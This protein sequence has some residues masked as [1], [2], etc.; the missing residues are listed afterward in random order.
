MKKN[1]RRIPACMLSAAMI[2]SLF[3]AYPTVDAQAE[4][5]LNNTY[6]YGFDDSDSLPSEFTTL[7][8]SVSSVANGI[9]TVT[10]STVNPR[11]YLNQPIDTDG[12]SQL[13]VRMKTSLTGSS[14]DT[15]K[16][17]VFFKDTD[18]ANNYQKDGV[19]CK[20]EKSNIPLATDGYVTYTLDLSSH[21]KYS[22]LDTITTIRIDIV[23]K[24]GSVDIDYIMLSKADSTTKTWDFTSSSDT[25]GSSDKDVWFLDKKGGSTGN[26]A[27]V[28]DG[29]LKIG[30]GAAVVNNALTVV[31]MKL[32]PSTPIE[33]ADYDYLEV[34]MKHD[35]SSGTYAQAD[36]NDMTLYLQGSTHNAD[37]TTTNFSIHNNNRKVITISDTSGNSCIRYIFPLSGTM[38]GGTSIDDAEITMLRLDPIRNQGTCEID[39]IRLVP[40][41][42]AVT[43]GTFRAY[44]NGV[45]IEKFTSGKLTAGIEVN[46]YNET[47]NAMAIIAQFNSD[48]RMIGS[49]RKDY[50]LSGNI[51]ADVSLDIEQTEGTYLKYFLFEKDTLRPLIKSRVIYPYSDALVENV[52]KMYP[53]FT[54]KAATFSFDDGVA[55]DITTVAS[56][57]K[58]GAKAT[59]NVVAKRSDGTTNRLLANYNDKGNTDAERFAYIKNLYSGHEIANH[60][61]SH[62]SAGLEEGQTSTNSSGVTLYGISGSDLVQNIMD[63]HQYIEDNL[64]IEMHGIA[65]PQSNPP[66]SDKVDT[67]KKA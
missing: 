32:T 55:Q 31:Q 20:V 65:W 47:V 8:T 13:T 39:S 38:A 44:R 23:D 53:G 37:G 16:M 12:V 64:G 27:A 26:T 2:F 1:R 34:I 5:Y 57:N 17:I 66:I 45:E 14:G 25:G 67:M 51:K 61:Y 35:I 30:V 54:T 52:M 58:Y 9:W 24:L 11:I 56:L 29:V 4:D 28:E 60:S 42:R 22:S 10:G 21:Q 41:S 19:T 33:T 50:T 48:S 49:S 15:A 6:F 40:K 3:T 43:F 7:N 59:F 36:K 62:P 46:A 63:N 18:M